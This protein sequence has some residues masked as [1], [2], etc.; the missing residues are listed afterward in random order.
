MPLFT[1]PEIAKMAMKS[2]GAGP[3]RTSLC[4]RLCDCGGELVFTEPGVTHMNPPRKRVWCAKCKSDSFL[5]VGDI[6]DTMD[7]TDQLTLK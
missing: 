2:L 4:E 7:I 3:R 6:G 5:H 1:D